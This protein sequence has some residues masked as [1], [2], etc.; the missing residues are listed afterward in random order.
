MS[1]P[2][3]QSCQKTESP[4][5][6][7]QWR[8]TFCLF[9]FFN[10]I[11]SFVAALGLCC[12]ELAFCSCGQQGLLPGCS[13][14]ASRAVEHRLSGAEA[15]RGLSGCGFLDS[16]TQARWLWCTG[17]VVPWHVGSSRPRDRTC[18][19]CIGRQI[20]YHWVAREAMHLLNKVCRACV[21]TLPT[22][23]TCTERSC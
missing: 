5:C 13:A 2:S 8:R 17:L 16:G 10:I 20:L 12:C 7:R 11:Y 4:L 1:Y 14:Q 6:R 15:A 23:H 22:G 3:T 19:S 9:F 18:V 21:F